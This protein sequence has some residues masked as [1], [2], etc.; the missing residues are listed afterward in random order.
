MRRTSFATTTAAVAAA[1]ALALTAE[2]T[3]S[4][5]SQSETLSFMDASSTSEV[6]G[7]VATGAF[8]DAGTILINGPGRH[9]GTMLL[10]DGTIKAKARFTK[11]PN[12]D[13]NPTTCFVTERSAG[14]LELLSGTRAYKGIT[15][16]GTFTQSASEIVPTVRGKCSL[17]SGAFVGSQQTI[18]AHLRVSLP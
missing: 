11:A 6:F 7:V 17:S 2:A 12:V 14:T 4:T 5:P 10:S 8:T 18:T 3:A 1:V 13:V 15:G 9:P 16:S